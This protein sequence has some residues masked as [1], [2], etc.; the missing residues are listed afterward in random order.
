MPVDRRRCRQPSGTLP[1]PDPSVKYARCRR[2]VTLSQGGADRVGRAVLGPPMRGG[3]ML[4]RRGKAFAKVEMDAPAR[5]VGVGTVDR[6]L[7]GLCGSPADTG[8]AT[9][10]FCGH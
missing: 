4:I 10:D 5:R 6:C 2:I 9:P 7:T 1:F 3:R 8:T